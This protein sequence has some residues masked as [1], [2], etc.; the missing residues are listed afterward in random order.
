MHSH[1]LSLSLSLSLT[2]QIPVTVVVSEDTV[3]LGW[4]NFQQ[5]PLPRLQTLPSRETLKPPFSEVEQRDI[6]DIEQLVSGHCA[7]QTS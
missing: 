4:E 5:W 3:F 6:T 2:D 1:T 7:N